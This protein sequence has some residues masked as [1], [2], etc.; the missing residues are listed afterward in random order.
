MSTQS[1]WDNALEYIKEE[2][3]PIVFQEYIEPILP[4]HSTNETFVLKI[5]E[6]YKKTAIEN[7]Y[8]YLIVKALR[9]AT[10]GKNVTVKYVTDDSEYSRP[11]AEKEQSFSSYAEK[12]SAYSFNPK[13]T[14]D[15]FVV[16]TNNRLAH[17]ASLA[18][19]QSPGKK[20]NPLFIY[21]GVGLGK[22]HL[23][24]AIAQHIL[25]ENEHFKVSFVSSE[26]FTNEFIDAIRRES[27][28]QFRNKYRN[29]DVL[30]VDDIQFLSGKEGTQEEFFHTFNDLYNAGKQIIL[31]SDKPP[32]DIPNLEERLRSRF[33]WGLSCD[34]APPNFETRVAIL[35]RKAEDENFEV[36]NE[37]LEYIAEKVVSNIREL[38][39][40]LLKV[41]VL[42]EMEQKPLTI[43][44]LN[45]SLKDMFASTEKRISSELIIQT[46]SKY[47]NVSYG[48]I[49][50]SKRTMNIANARQIGMYLMR[51][52]TD[53][54]LQNIGDSFGGRDYSTV[55][56]ACGKVKDKSEEDDNFKKE[57]SYII[58]EIK[59]NN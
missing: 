15:T 30:L 49:L 26:K 42:C 13:Y 22:T 43:Q 56:H 54:S 48:D 18:V 19:S 21:G 57:L 27:N 8:H 10:G 17:A 29:V 59:N 25:S 46:V 1:V 14:F 50:S 23:M 39:G 7:M 33:E 44:K 38:E 24:Q 47:Y 40:V 16:G 45:E 58:T 53:L 9:Y 37:I 51:E 36:S 41:K 12:Q 6:E 55:I 5:A 11:I 4:V 2:L 28:I 35:R 20:Y 52:L 32:K 31:T 3:T 34:I